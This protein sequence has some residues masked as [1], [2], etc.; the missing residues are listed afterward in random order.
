MKAELNNYQKGTVRF[1]LPQLAPGPHT[2]TIKAWDAVNNSSEYCV[3][4]TVVND[5]ELVFDHVLNYPNPFT[6]KTSF[7]FEHNQ[8]GLDL[9]A[10][11][12]IFTVTGKLI[13][14]LRQTINTPGNRSNDIEWDGRDDYGDKVGRGVYL[15]RLTVQTAMV[16]LP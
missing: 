2:L 8:P 10:K 3:E 5:E 4:F 7:W 9:E 12:E 15:Y 11:V 16:K 13:K 6:T 1:Q 14:T